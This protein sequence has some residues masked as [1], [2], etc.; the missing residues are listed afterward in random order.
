MKKTVCLTGVLT[1]LLT[2]GCLVSE[3]G[4]HGRGHGRE[5]Y[6]HRSEVIVGPPPIVVRAPVVV[7]R[8]P[9]IIVR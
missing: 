7:V 4:W 9:E 2:S 6:E 1:L 8:P 5:R 3:G